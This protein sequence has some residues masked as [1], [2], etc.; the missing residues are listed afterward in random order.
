MRIKKIYK[1]LL[2]IIAFQNSLF[3]LLQIIIIKVT[4]QLF[5]LINNCIDDRLHFILSIKRREIIIKQL[6][7]YNIN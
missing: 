4:Y 3:F 6:I 2:V 5:F 1:N 7:L